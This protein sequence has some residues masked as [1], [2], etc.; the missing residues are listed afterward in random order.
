MAQF[1]VS[2]KLWNDCIIM[3]KIDLDIC[4]YCIYL[5]RRVC[6][7]AVVAVRVR[8]TVGWSAAAAAQREGRRKLL[9]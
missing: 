3:F 7:V 6:T 1:T 4:L 8:Q 5:L 2:H 9:I